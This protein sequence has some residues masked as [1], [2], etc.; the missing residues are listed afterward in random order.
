MVGEI[1]TFRT[2]GFHFLRVLC[3]SLDGPACT[4]GETAEDTYDFHGSLALLPCWM[5][6]FHQKL[7]FVTVFDA[8]THWGLGRWLSG[9]SN[10]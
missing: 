2:D 9:S 8:D 5:L 4:L 3:V 7:N 10:C 1:A 6:F